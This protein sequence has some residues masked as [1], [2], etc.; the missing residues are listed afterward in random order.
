[1]SELSTSFSSNQKATIKIYS[2]KKNPIIKEKFT[3]IKNY[4]KLQK[5]S[6]AKKYINLISLYNTLSTIEHLNLYFYSFEIT[7]NLYIKYPNI[8]QKK[9][10]NS[11]NISS[12]NINT[13]IYLMELSYYIKKMM[14]YFHN[15]GKELKLQKK[16]II[17]SKIYQ[18]CEILHK[19]KEFLLE[20][21]F[22]NELSDNE[23]YIEIM[24]SYMLGEIYQRKNVLYKNL[25]K[26]LIEQK[27][28]YIK[29][30]FSTDYEILKKNFIDESFN[31]FSKEL[32]EGENCYLISTYWIKTFIYY[33][34][35]ISKE[36]NNEENDIELGELLFQ[37]SKTF[38]L[39]YKPNLE[40]EKFYIYAPAYPGPLNNFNITGNCNFWFDPKKGEEYTNQ[41]L[42]NKAAENSYQIIDEYFFMLLSKLFGSPINEISR[43]IH[44][45]ENSFPEI[46]THLLKYKILIL[47]K[48]LLNDEELVHLIRLKKIQISKEKTFNQLVNKIVRALNY[49]IE[50]IKGEILLKNYD[51]ERKLKFHIIIPDFIEQEK[52]KNILYNI[53]EYFY[54]NNYTYFE[55]ING[56]E[57]SEEDLDKRLEEMKIGEEDVIIIEFILEKNENFFLN[58]KS[59]NDYPRCSLCSNPIS[60]SP[61]FCEKCNYFFYCSE[62]CRKDDKK[63]INH[64]ETL[65]KLYKKKFALHDIL[66]VDIKTLLNPRSNH[67]LTGLKNL[68]NTCFMNSAIQCLSSV[69]ELTKYFLLKK[70]A[71]EI[72]KSNKNGAQGKIAEAYYSLISELWNGN[73]RYINPWDFRQIFVSFVKQFAGFSQQDS[74][75]MLTFILDSLNEDLNRVKIKP[76]SELKEKSENETE[77]EAS[78]RWW[79]NHIERENSIIVDLFH[80]QFKSVVKCPECDKISTIYD[81]FMN[82]GLPIPS[83]QSK[84]RI[85]YLEENEVKNEVKELLFFYKCDDKTTVREI[86]SKLFDDIKNSK[87]NILNNKNISLNI[88][89]IIVG[90]NKKFKKYL[91]N[92]QEFITSNYI[93]DNYE[94]LFYLIEKK[95]SIQNFF[96]CFITPVRISDDEVQILFFPKIFKF[97]INYTIK[98]MYFHFFLYYRKLF[99]DIKNFTYT[100]FLQNLSE[101]NIRELNKEFNEY[102]EYIETTPFKLYIV[103]NVPKKDKFSC[104]YCNRSCKYCSFNF[105]FNDSL[106][107]LYQSQKIKRPFL[108]YIEILSYSDKIFCENTLP[109][110]N[111][112]KDLLIKNKEISIYDCFEAFR[113]EEKLEKDNSWY[114]SYCKKNQEAFKKLEIYRAPNVLIVQLK[115]FDCKTESIYEGFIKNKKNESLVNFPLKNLDIGKYVVEENSRKDCLY[116][117]CAI[118]QHFGSLSSGHYTALC[119]NDDEWY[120][121]DD[122]KISKITN[123]KSVVSKGAYIL[124]FRKKSLGNNKSQKNED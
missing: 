42:T 93:D 94:A 31:L 71:E 103:N 62:K 40:N 25:N 16:K 80:G 29:N 17:L 6:E 88:E 123:A 3:K 124:I 82:L 20:Y 83:A 122:E 43:K 76:Y 119:L 64:H 60:Q 13:N 90:K 24:D 114:C 7:K 11:N 10:K 109:I 120:N 100:N 66:S 44:Y 78:L 8:N 32:K 47:C 84:M 36:S 15:Y 116:D 65:D 98:E 106:L 55:K 118:S 104:E 4:L 58:V 56:K 19:E 110:K 18:F 38:N 54:N 113:T 33:L 30:K 2:D 95:N 74:D 21:Y 35:I 50:L 101:N 79:K 57:I 115:R 12:N 77:E 87:K 97:D 91:E 73:S 85:K 111:F 41:F 72:N 117:L 75:E 34:N 37:F 107:K 89:G 112:S 39:Y 105:K 49:E 63:H 102:F 9:P 121:F 46:E 27:K 26:E 69:Q 1:M 67:G 22:I 52:D 61:I 48:N 81:P 96:Q 23:K 70:Y 14:K 92:D 108:F 28:N 51:H 68:G 5:Y 59:V 86:K 53:L 45:K 99:K